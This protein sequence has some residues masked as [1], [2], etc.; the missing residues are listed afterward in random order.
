MELDSLGQLEN[1]DTMMDKNNKD[2]LC[3]YL[4]DT[5]YELYK[6]MRSNDSIKHMI[7]TNLANKI[8]TESMIEYEKLHEVVVK[9]SIEHS[10]IW[11]RIRTS[12]ARY[13]Y[14]KGLF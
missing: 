5:V 13:I 4:S 10:C 6:R 14:I 1:R 8:K 12:L 3:K 2:S 9:H 7:R 11:L